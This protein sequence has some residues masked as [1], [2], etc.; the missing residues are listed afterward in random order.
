MIRIC[1]ILFLWIPF[2]QIMFSETIFNDPG[3][4]YDDD[5]H[6]KIHRD[7]VLYVQRILILGDSH[8]LGHF[9]E[10]LQKGIHETG[11]YDILSV[12]I[13][14]AGSRNF[15][16]PMR[17]LCC[18]YA[19]RESKY[20]EKISSFD[21]I[22]KIEGSDRHSGETVGKFFR[23]K[24]ENVLNI[25]DPNIVI[26]ALGHNNINDH[27]NLINIIRTYNSQVKII[28]IA[29]FRNKLIQRQ[30]F[31][32]K[33]VASK[34]NVFLVRSDDI[35]GSDNETCAHY[36]GWIAQNWASKVIERLQSE[37]V[38]DIHQ[39]FSIKPI[40]WPV[41]FDTLPFL[42]KF[43]EDELFFIFSAEKPSYFQLIT[44][45]SSSQYN[46]APRYL[47]RIFSNENSKFKKPVFINDIEGNSYS[48]VV[49]G[50]AVWMGENLRT[51][52]FRN[53]EPVN[54]SVRAE[55]NKDQ[56]PAFRKYL[57][58]NLKAAPEAVLY[59]WDAVNSS[60]GL[61][62]D[63]WHIPDY[64]DWKNLNDHL[65]NPEAFFINA[66]VWI[67]NDGRVMNENNSDFFWT[68]I[69]VTDITRSAWV[70]S[71]DKTSR[72]LILLNRNCQFF[73]PVR[74]VKD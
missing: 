49:I 26:I 74:C 15:T 42:K 35:L 47:N 73:I 14:G 70:G 65:N 37:I 53:G 56:Q 63:G 33:Q 8:L 40:D 20:N 22:R 69:R 12:A 66:H 5:L 23:G 45:I 39:V 32:I 44:G 48:T 7:S 46:F 21:K 60:N 6:K 24:L 31:D 1:Y 18:G 64:A 38:P 61:C 27:Q 13:G 10:M 52:R 25:F 16:L 68:N 41:S 59:N 50:N 62:P 55:N 58:T 29:P 36:F 2:L 51:T 57:N 54:L 30:L 34:N 19:I 9:G 11:N 3:H 71:F 4:E 28:W 72:A 43:A 17:N 67:H